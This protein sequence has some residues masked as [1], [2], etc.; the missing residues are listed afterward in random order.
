[1]SYSVTVKLALYKQILLSCKRY[2]SIK[3]VQIYE[4]IRREFRNNS[5]LTD[6]A[7]IKRQID[8]AVKGLAQLNMY[9]NLN[10]KAHSWEVTLDDSLMADRRVRKEEKDLEK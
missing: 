5:K 4:E 9:S 3:R 2:P 8:V 10:P 7:A 1:M 6:P